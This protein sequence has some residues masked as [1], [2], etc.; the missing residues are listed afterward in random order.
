MSVLSKIFEDAEIFFIDQLMAEEGAPRKKMTDKQR[1]IFLQDLIWK[2][3]YDVR[4]EKG[5][6]SDKQF[7]RELLQG[8]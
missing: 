3:H 1:I 2:L 4:N 5:S 7:H 8:H 6:A